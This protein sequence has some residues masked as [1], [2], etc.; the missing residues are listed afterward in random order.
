MKNAN[1]KIIKQIASD[2][3]VSENKVSSTV[4]LLQADN[5]VPFIARYRKEVTG[6]LDETQNYEIQKQLGYYS[7]LEERKQTILKTIEA[8]GKLTDE[9]KEE[10]EACLNKKDLEDIYLPYKPKRRTKADKAIEAGL[11]PLARLMIVEQDITSG[12]VE[13]YAAKYVNPEKGINTP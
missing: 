13:D 12:S 2:L 5:T 9:L 11:R 10:I 7:E 8:Q 1:E 6:S 4:E 3:S